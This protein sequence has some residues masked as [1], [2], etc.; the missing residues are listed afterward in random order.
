MM[1]FFKFIRGLP[2]R[3]SPRW[4]WPLRKVRN[5]NIPAGERDFFE[6]YGETVISMK[7][8]GSF[9]QDEQHARAWLTER[10][11]Y[12]ERRE[13]WISARDLI[14][15][16]VII[17]LIGWEIHLSYRQERLQTQDFERQQQLLT[18]LQNSSAEIFASLQKLVAAQDAS[19]K[20]LQQEQAERIKKPKL[21]LY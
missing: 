8:S 3:A 6:R 9:D 21:A 17:A 19:L 4:P 14:L 2:N 11:D 7:V 1:Q 15:D 20:I 10:A 18:N 12:H 5:A 13:Q 16:L